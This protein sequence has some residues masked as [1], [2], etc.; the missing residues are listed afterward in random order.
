[1]I[2][3]WPLVYRIGPSNL[4]L[5]LC[6]WGRLER[7]PGRAFCLM[8][9]AAQLPLKIKQVPKDRALRLPR[10]CVH[11]PQRRADTFPVSPVHPRAV[12]PDHAPPVHLA[13]TLPIIPL[14]ASP[15]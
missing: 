14:L 10:T 5:S 6:L 1:M 12:P 13:V 7:A 11:G 15:L 9:W 3:H 4:P 8:I 2:E